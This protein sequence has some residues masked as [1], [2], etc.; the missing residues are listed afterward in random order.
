MH[1]AGAIPGCV[2]EGQWLVGLRDQPPAGQTG[3]VSPGDMRVGNRISCR[4]GLHLWVVLVF[5]AFCNK[6]PQTGGGR[7]TYRSR[8][9]FS[10]S[11]GS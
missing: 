10:P 5:W 1:V 7:G 2:R 3:K 9:L 6:V 11:C 8:H 4:G